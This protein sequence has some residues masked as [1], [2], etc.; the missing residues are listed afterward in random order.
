MTQRPDR[1]MNPTNEL[2][3]ERNRAAA[4]RTITS[5]IQ[6]SIA[7]IG[8]GIAFER[9]FNAI[10]E[11]FP[12]SAPIVNELVSEAIGLGAIGFGL[13]MLG[14][15]VIAYYKE[16]NYLE[17]EDYLYRAERFSDLFLIMASSVILFGIVSIAAIFAIVSMEW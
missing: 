10:S 5:W 7:L 13:F 17:R 3:K 9:I 16:I 8:F 15:A 12:Q 2:A 14:M 6:N 4:E 1:P 11:T